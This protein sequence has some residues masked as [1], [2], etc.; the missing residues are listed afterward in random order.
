ME[1]KRKIIPPVYLVVALLVMAALHFLV[2]VGRFIATPYSYLG[3][4]PLVGGIVMAASASNAFRGAGTPVLPFERSTALVTSGL[5]RVTR[6]PMYLGMVL[7]LAGT[8]L[9][10]GTVGTLLP[11]PFFV[12]A[13]RRNFILG[14]ERFLEEIF[15][16]QYLRYKE[17][18]RR[19]L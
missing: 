1:Q 2:P 9:L 19:W 15:G 11:I 17:R 7:V 8:A 6:N 5:Y 4:I 10:F 14:E 13:I 3:A 16:A 12:W 18:V